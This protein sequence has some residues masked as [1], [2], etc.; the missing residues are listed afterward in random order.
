M[1]FERSRL[2]GRFCL[3]TLAH[4][5]HMLCYLKTH[6][7][8]IS[9]CGGL[10]SHAPRTTYWQLVESCRAVTAHNTCH[11]CLVRF[12][13]IDRQ[14]EVTDLSTQTAWRPRHERTHTRCHAAMVC[15][16]F[17]ETLGTETRASGSRVLL[18]WRIF[19]GW[20]CLRS[21]GDYRFWCTTTSLGAFAVT[22]CR[23]LV[24]LL[25]P[26]PHQVPLVA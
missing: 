4:G 9:I 14:V 18:A 10:S 25:C 11:C 21:V 6:K 17:P 13:H 5:P 24:L 3:R 15:H 19:G 7:Q 12:C 1:W 20:K 8:P 23:R 22:L 16:G 26:S 2:G